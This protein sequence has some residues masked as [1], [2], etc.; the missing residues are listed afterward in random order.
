[1]AQDT[2]EREVARVVKKVFGRDREG[3]AF[4]RWLCGLVAERKQRFYPRLDC[5]IVDYHFT[6]KEHGAH[7]EVAYILNAGGGESLAS[8]DNHQIS[9]H[10]VPRRGPFGGPFGFKRS[11]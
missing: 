5:Y 11:E 9:D 8:G 4:F 7:L 1:M 6:H 2:Q 3:A 10:D